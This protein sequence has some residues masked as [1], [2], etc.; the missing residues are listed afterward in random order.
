MAFSLEELASPGLYMSG[1]FEL[2]M[3]TKIEG[4]SMQSGQVKT[5][6]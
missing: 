5:A 6:A 2:L 4:L 1:A 3:E